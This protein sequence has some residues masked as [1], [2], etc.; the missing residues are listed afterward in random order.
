M[1]EISVKLKKTYANFCLGHTGQT[2]SLHVK[3]E[4]IKFLIRY[5]TALKRLRTA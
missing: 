3:P 2:T 4:N 1:Q 5:L